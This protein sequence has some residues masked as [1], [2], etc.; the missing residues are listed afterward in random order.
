M[1][2]KTKADGCCASTEEN[3]DQKETKIKTGFEYKSKNSMFIVSQAHFTKLFTKKK[4]EN[5]K[6]IIKNYIHF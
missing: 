1:Y 3:S 4:R 2:K 5:I 6:K